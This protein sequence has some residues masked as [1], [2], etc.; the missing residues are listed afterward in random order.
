MGGKSAFSFFCPMF[1]FLSRSSSSRR[2]D[3]DGD[4]TSDWEYNRPARYGSKVRSSDEDYGWWVG[5]RDVDRKA[6]DYINDFHQ[7]KQQ[8]SA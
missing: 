1:S 3:E 7:R 6:A 8:V 2:Y 5:E 4:Y